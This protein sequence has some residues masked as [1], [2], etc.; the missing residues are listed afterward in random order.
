MPRAVSWCKLNLNFQSDAVMERNSG[1]LHANSQLRA[2]REKCYKN[3]VFPLDPE[4][5]REFVEQASILECIRGFR[6]CYML[7]LQTAAHLLGFE[8]RLSRNRRREATIRNRRCPVQFVI[9]LRFENQL[10][11]KFIVMLNNYKLMVNSCL[12]DFGVRLRMEFGMVMVPRVFRE[13]WDWGL[14]P[15]DADTASFRPF[16]RREVSMAILV[17]EAACDRIFVLGKYIAELCLR[18]LEDNR[19]PRQSVLHIHQSH[20]HTG[21]FRDG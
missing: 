20:V 8:A 15:H 21:I 2:N 16:P 13:L 11:E 7:K 3:I 18:W 4:L 1:R 19:N 14:F 6:F 17:S 12:M 9:P 10:L 5:R